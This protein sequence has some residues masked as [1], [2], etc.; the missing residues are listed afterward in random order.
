MKIKQENVIINKIRNIMM[1]LL[2]SISLSGCGSISDGEYAASVTLTGGSG[3]ASIDSPCKVTV[4]NGKATA[5]IVWSS[6]NYDYMIVDGKRYEPVNEEGNSEFII[7]I[8]L[9]KKMKVQADTVA[10]STPHLI[11]YELF[12]SV[13]ESEKENDEETYDDTADIADKALIATPPEIPGLTYIETDKNAYADCYAIHRYEDDY[14]VISVYD[15]RNYL[16][17]PEGGTVPKGLKDVTIIQKPVDRIYLAASS[18]MCQFDSI[19]AVDKI[20]LSGI[21]RDNWYIDAAKENMDAG[22]LEY[23]GKYSAPDYERIVAKDITLAVES[24]MILHTPKVMEKLEKLGVPVFVD[25]SSYESDPFGRCEWIKIY[26]LL[27]DKEDEAKRAFDEQVSFG[28]ALENMDATGKKI[29]FFSINSKHLINT[30]GGGDYFSKMIEKAGG[31]YLAPKNVDSKAHS[32]NLSVS[33]EA[34]YDYAKDADILIYNSTIEDCPDSLE[35]LK[36]EDAIFADFKAVK[37]GDVWY[38][39][40]SLYQFTDRSGTIIKDLNDII[41]GNADDTEFFHRLR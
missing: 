28:K 41:T 18:A 39:D 29:A 6:P 37:S 11:D 33:M 21:E 34:F 14:A 38:T 5:D 17:V 2:I 15:G 36:S 40:K 19:G 9:E 23:G 31:E 25:R 20:T 12:F 27:S 3:R 8:T 30:R 22:T 4:E 32:A 16:V 7:P 35:A 13:K 24:T 1:F 26:G 10:M